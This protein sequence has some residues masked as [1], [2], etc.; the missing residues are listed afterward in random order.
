MKAL[1]LYLPLVGIPALALVGVLHAGERLEAPPGL[2]GE[3]SIRSAGFDAPM[4]GPA[5]TDAGCITAAIVDSVHRMVITQSGSRADAIVR[6]ADGLDWGTATLRVRSGGAIGA[7]Q[8]VGRSNTHRCST[9]VLSLAFESRVPDSLE[10]VIAQP[11][12]TDCQSARF[13]ARR[14]HP[15]SE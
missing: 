5:A 9:A 3:W 7:L 14:R 2:H 13:V 15:A 10:M 6:T 4:A 12:C 8:P 1:R 11:G